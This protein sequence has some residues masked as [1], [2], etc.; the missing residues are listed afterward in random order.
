MFAAA[1]RRCLTVPVAGV[2]AVWVPIRYRNRE[3]TEPV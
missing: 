3:R 1:Y 2:A